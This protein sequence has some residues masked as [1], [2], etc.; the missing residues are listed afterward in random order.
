M[1]RL[2][3]LTN[4][5]DRAES[6]SKDIHKEGVSD[7]NFHI[8][9]RDRDGL[10][11]HHLHSTNTLIHERDVIRISERGAIFG[12]I[13]GI[14]AILAFFIMIPG[15]PIRL[16]SEVLILL[17]CLAFGVSGAFLG[18]IVGLA[19]ENAKIRCF[20]EDLDA[21]NYLLMIDVRKKDSVQ[22][23][24]MMLLQHSVVRAGEGSS[25]ISPFQVPVNI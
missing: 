3:Y 20:H 8:M 2:Y 18:G 5:I 19:M 1:K 9:S 16:V 6:V 11:K 17:V 23:E 22:I 12:L 10:T 13:S 21:G 14:C 4:S 25:I 15:V 24:K 7:W